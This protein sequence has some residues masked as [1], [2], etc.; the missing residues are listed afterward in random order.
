[1]EGL[2]H[3]APAGGGRESMECYDTQYLAVRRRPRR[4]IFV[5][6]YTPALTR[7]ACAGARPAPACAHTSFLSAPP[8]EAQRVARAHRGVLRRICPARSGRDGS[9]AL[10]VEGA[11]Q[12]WRLSAGKRQSPA[13]ASRGREP[14]STRIAREGPPLFW[15]ISGSHSIGRSGTMAVPDRGSPPT[16]SLPQQYPQISVEENLKHG[17]SNSREAAV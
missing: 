5:L 14:R 9:P 15:S 1:M 7:A 4:R 2:R 3:G 17:L 12:R 16:L 13:P 6:G 11:G 10:L 8:C